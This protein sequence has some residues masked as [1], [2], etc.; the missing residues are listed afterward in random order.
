M[1]P[2]PELNLLYG[3][4]PSLDGAYL[5]N[6][7]R[8]F[9]AAENGVQEPQQAA[10]AFEGLRGAQDR[11]Q[12]PARSSNTVTSNLLLLRPHGFRQDLGA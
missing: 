11:I 7:F 3:Q 5:R 2:E 12:N 1:D 4:E 6:V 8:R 9:V 10:A